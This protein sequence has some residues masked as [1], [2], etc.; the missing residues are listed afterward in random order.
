VRINF[1]TLG[2]RRDGA[3]LALL[4]ITGSFGIVVQASDK[5]KECFS[6]CALRGCSRGPRGASSL[7]SRCTSS[8]APRVGG[9]RRNVS[10]M[11]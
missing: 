6:W 1:P 8:A 3:A 2:G 5:Q 7:P 10:E 9:V 4:A 11:T